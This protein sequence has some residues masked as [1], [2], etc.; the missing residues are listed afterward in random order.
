M[1]AL[2]HPMEGQQLKPAGGLINDQ[3]I[4]AT[5]SLTLHEQDITCE[6]I[7]VLHPVWCLL[8]SDEQPDRL[9]IFGAEDAVVYRRVVDSE[10]ITQP[11]SG[12]DRAHPK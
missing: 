11:L 3:V 2:A 12:V 6:V 4:R 1:L 10:Q 7:D 9:R 8:L 5:T